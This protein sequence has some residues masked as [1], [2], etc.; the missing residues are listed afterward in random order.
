[1]ES[2]VEK[3]YDGIYSKLAFC[4]RFWKN[5]IL[6]IHGKTSSI[7]LKKN[8]WSLACFS[9]M[10]DKKLKGGVSQPYK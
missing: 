1:M 6:T 5:S 3:G 7:K 2:D 9:Y 8:P 10:D 4:E